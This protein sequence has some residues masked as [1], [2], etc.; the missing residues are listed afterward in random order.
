MLPPTLPLLSSNQDLP[1]AGAQAHRPA[2]SRSCARVAGSRWRRRRPSGS[3][4]AAPRAREPVGG[5]VGGSLSA[6]RTWKGQIYWQC[7]R[8]GK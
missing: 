8:A 6:S 4:G 1:H 3:L 5:S 2:M 7:R